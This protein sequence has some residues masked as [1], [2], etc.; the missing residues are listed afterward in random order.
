MV[1]LR[2]VRPSIVVEVSFVEWTL[3]GNLRHAT[4]FGVRDDKRPSDV[5]REIG[6]T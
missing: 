1:T 3:D 5:R 6:R 4:F 2:W